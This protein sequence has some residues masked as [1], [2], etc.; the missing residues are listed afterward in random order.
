MACWQHVLETGANSH[1]T[2]KVDDNLCH[3]PKEVPIELN[4]KR[5][6]ER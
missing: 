2:V 5:A 3:R 1:V 6:F 4:L